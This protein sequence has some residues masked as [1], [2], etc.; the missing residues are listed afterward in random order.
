VSSLHVERLIMRRCGRGTFAVAVL[1]GLGLGGP[2]LGAQLPAGFVYLSEVAP[3]IL[4]DI[5]YAG[6]DNFTGRKVS[7]YDAPQCIL[8]REVAEALG[9][10][11]AEL[12]EQSLG[13]KVYDCYRPARATRAFLKWIGDEAA[14]GSKRYFPRTD[15]ATLHTQGYIS[16]NSAHSRGTAVDLT[17]V[18]LPAAEQ[19]AFDG[20]ARYGPC[21]GPAGNRA[22]DNSLDMGTGFDCFDV[23]S[24]TESPAVTAEQ[25]DMRRLLRTVMR[26]HGFQSYWRE[27]WHFSFATPTPGPARDFAIEPPRSAP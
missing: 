17:L 18:W 13:L 8:L 11:Q 25:R 19:Q 21:N 16:P 12:R 23:M 1:L 4:Q 24:Q 20:S 14:A 3:D 10:V 26:K 27:W 5:R 9:R 22:P 6:P 2:A 7:G 15:K